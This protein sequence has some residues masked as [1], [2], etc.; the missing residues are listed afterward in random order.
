MICVCL[1]V[2]N[3]GN[4]K[5]NS[6]LNKGT[7][8]G[9]ENGCLVGISAADSGPPPN[10]LWMDRSLHQGNHHSAHCFSFTRVPLHS[11]IAGTRQTGRSPRGFP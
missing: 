1:V 5:Q 9:E 4:P 11:Q 3:K 2:E 6:Q 10:I 8:S 7:N